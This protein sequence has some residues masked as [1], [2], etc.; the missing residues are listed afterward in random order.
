MTGA[1]KKIDWDRIT[2]GLPAFLTMILMPLTFSIST[3]LAAGF[4]SYSILKL[5]RGEGR[6]VH[7]L[8]HVIAACIGVG[9]AALRIAGYLSSKGLEPQ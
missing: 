7:V 8:V 9:Y 2:E 4:V 5:V 6:K 3:G 1:L